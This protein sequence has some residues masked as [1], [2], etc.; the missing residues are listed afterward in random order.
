MSDSPT[1]A[2]RPHESASGPCWYTASMG[3][4][5]GVTPGELTSLRDHLSGCLATRG[6]LFHLQRHTDAV[7]G[8]M[9]GRLITSVVVVGLVA[10]L[11]WLL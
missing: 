6:R 10:A 8:F 4:D 3:G 11:V 7:L 1:T 2:P 9:A 5:T